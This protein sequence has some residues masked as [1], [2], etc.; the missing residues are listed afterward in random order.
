MKSMKRRTRILLPLL[1]FAALGAGLVVAKGC[2]TTYT[3]P[4]I[5]AEGKLVGEVFPTVT[6]E[7]LAGE[8][9]ELPAAYAG[10]PAVILVGYQQRAQ[11]DIDRWVMGLIQADVDAPMLEV[12][13][14]PGLAAAF[15]SDLIDQTMRDG[16]AEEDWAMIMTLY[17]QAAQPLAEFTGT[18][19]GQMTRVF[20]LDAD[21]RVAWFDD[22]GFTARKALVVDRI[23]DMLQATR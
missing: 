16:I 2:S 13:A 3:A 9:I 11:F 20:V 15:A 8:A 21:G 17:G 4:A 6:G 18:E 12:P 14:V 19:R 22:G 10:E 7:S 1:A 23:V 5:V